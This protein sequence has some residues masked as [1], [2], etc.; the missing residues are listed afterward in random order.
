MASES[1]A[2]T[3]TPTDVGLKRE[4]GLIGAT[5]ASETSIIGSGWLF[6]PQ[7]A[8]IAGAPWLTGSSAGIVIIV[9]ALSHAEL[10]GDVPRLRRHGALPALRLRRRR[11]ASFGWFS[12]L[13][14]ATVAP[15]EVLAMITY[16]STTPSPAAGY[17]ADKRADHE[18]ARRRRHPDG[19]L[20][21]D[22]L[23]RRPQARAAQQRGDVVEGRGPAAD[24][25][26]A[27]DRQLPR[28]ATSPP[29]TASA[30]TASRASSPRSRP[31]GIIFALPRLRAGRPARR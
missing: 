14:A 15:I 1:V 8:L 19:D 17:N 23:P 9:L 10:G 31:A 2:E 12:W 4:L 7:K 22:Q 28:R 16:A 24:H 29:P 27:G 11:R 25:P 18:R 21:G 5:W 6:G 20:H 30:P 26:R 3:V 13:Q